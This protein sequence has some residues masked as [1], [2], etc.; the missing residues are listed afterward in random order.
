M[1]GS[2]RRKV[3]LVT[4]SS[5]GLGRAMALELARS[6]HDV[7]VHYRA[8]EGPAQEVAEA[9]RGSGVRAATFAADIASPT[10]C[11]ELIGGV[12][13]AFGALDVLVNNAGITRDTLALRMKADDWQAVLD[14]NLSGAFHLSKA[15]LRGMLRSNWGRIVNVASVVGL[16]GN[17]GQSNYVAAKAGLIGLT[18][19]LA[20]EYATK[21][22]T[23]NA[24]APG[25]IVS[26]MTE[27]LPEA[28]TSRY[29]E[30][31]PAGRFGTA[32]EVARVV[33]FLASDDATYMTGQ[34]LVVDG[35]MVMP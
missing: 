20:R 35:G 15:A 31:I 13:D 19:A 1:T 28:I 3:A 6:G 33:A 7:A 18:K 16:M 29:L 26:D 22:V 24:V 5:R 23:V 11:A 8:S 17:I 21:G 9:A 32:E 12:V 10:A 25:F 34:T 30:Q 2:D 27:G 4:G 14:T